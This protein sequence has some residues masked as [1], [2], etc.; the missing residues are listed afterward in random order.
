MVAAIAA[1]TVAP[2]ALEGDRHGEA[3]VTSASQLF[4]FSLSAFLR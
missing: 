3:Q 1:G 2:Y 4:D